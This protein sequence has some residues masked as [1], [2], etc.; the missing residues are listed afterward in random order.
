MLE[1]LHTNNLSNTIIIRLFI[2][3]RSYTFDNR[4]LPYTELNALNS[5]ISFALSDIEI[6]YFWCLCFLEKKESLYY[7]TPGMHVHAV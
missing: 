7:S 4:L 6:Y 1:G 5:N 2:A 3:H